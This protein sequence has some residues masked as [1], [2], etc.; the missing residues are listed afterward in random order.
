MHSPRIFRFESLESTSTYAKENAAGLPIPSIICANTQTAGRGR[1]GKTFFSPHGTGL[2]FTLLFE[3]KD[4]A[5]MIT[6]AAANSVC[7]AIEKLTDKKPAIKWVNDIFLNGKKICGILSECFYLNGRRLIAL[8]IGINLTTEEFPADLPQAGSLDFD[9][10]KEKL[11]LEIAET[12]LDYA[13]NPDNKSVRNE[14]ESRL[15]IL[16]KKITYI[17][18]NIEYSATV[19]GINDFCHLLVKRSDGTNDILSSGEISI[20]I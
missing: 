6:L 14:Y 13:E 1:Q 7:R 4:E 20:K 9:G 12:M 3:T 2:Y 5:D 8:G 11:M 15:F 18:G 17:K 10:N 19:E 16:S